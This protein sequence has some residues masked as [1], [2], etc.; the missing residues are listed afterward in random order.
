M[1]KIRT[2]LQLNDYKP[3]VVNGIAYKANAQA[4]LQKYFS[5]L[6][7]YPMYINAANCEVALEVMKL[8]IEL[9]GFPLID[10][11]FDPSITTE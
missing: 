1:Q 10:L 9:G 7:T 2:E 8:S 3:T 4:V 5:T 6:M 11:V